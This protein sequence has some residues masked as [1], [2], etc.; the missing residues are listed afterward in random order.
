MCATE[1]A[2]DVWSSTLT[3]NQF[4]Y[5]CKRQTTA[6]YP[7]CYFYLLQSVWIL[8]AV[9][10]RMHNYRI[11]VASCAI[12]M[13]SQSVTWHSKAFEVPSLSQSSSSSTSSSMSSDWLLCTKTQ[14]C[15]T[16]SV[17][18]RQRTEAK[19]AALT[20]TCWLWSWR[21][22]TPVLINLHMQ[23]KQVNNEA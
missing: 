8:L 1:A 2:Y 21:R 7:L 10:V 9:H 5:V 15:G 11:I 3:P 4:L 19:T 17:R 18:G 22:W 12:L 14:S 13:M 20:L 6:F 16:P 23:K